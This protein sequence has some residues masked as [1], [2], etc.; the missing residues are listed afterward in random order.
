VV[1]STN[2]NDHHGIAEILLKVALNTIKP[3]L[4]PKSAIFGLI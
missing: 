2:K 3:N 4:K 1:Y